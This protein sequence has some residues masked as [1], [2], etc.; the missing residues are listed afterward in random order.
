MEN[1]ELTA[2]YLSREVDARMIGVIEKYFG[3]YETILDLGCGNGLYGKFL[4][5]K[6]EKVIGFDHDPELCS[7]A[8]KSGDYDQII[9]AE[10][11]D[12]NQKVPIVQ[13]TFCSEFLE[14]ISDTDLGNVLS[15]I[16]KITEV[17]DQL[18]LVPKSFEHMS[19][20]W[21]IVH[22]SAPTINCFE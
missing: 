10:V 11:A 19:A 14:H 8:Q 6:A 16:E 1:Q 5:K 4:R 13:A 15:E 9:C 12:L 21:R 7:S 3:H 2:R 18:G 20:D 17:V 22:S